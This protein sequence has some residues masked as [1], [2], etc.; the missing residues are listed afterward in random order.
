VGS[1]ALLVMMT[2]MTGHNRECGDDTSSKYN[3]AA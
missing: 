3:E 1:S 2:M